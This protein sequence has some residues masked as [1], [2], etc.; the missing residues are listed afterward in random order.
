MLNQSRL[1]RLLLLWDSVSCSLFL[2]YYL[3]PT[4]TATE[5]SEVPFFPHG[6]APRSLKGKITRRTRQK[7]HMWRR[8]RYVGSGRSSGSLLLLLLT[9]RLGSRL[10][11]LLPPFFRDLVCLTEGELVCAFSFL[12]PPLFFLSLL[13]LV[14]V[15]QGLS[16]AARA[17]LIFFLPSEQ[18]I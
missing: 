1:L 2:Y 17:P 14:V 13:R 7:S 10:I 9:K 18:E 15:D 11:L 5:S 6:S 3:P 16:E 8:R 4:A 12:P